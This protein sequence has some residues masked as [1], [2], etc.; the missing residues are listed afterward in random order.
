MMTE[1]VEECLKVVIKA[2]KKCGL[3]TGE[4]IAWCSTMLENDRVGFICERELRMLRS[5]FEASTS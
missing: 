2:L 3:P 4:V 5:Q 1:D